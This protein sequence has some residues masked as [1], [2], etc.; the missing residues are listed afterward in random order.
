MV[1]RKESRAD[2]FQRQISNLRQQLGNDQ[3]DDELYDDAEP[4]EQVDSPEFNAPALTRR[5]S[6]SSFRPGTQTVSD[7]EISVIAPDS[8]WSGT[9]RA[10]GSLQVYGQVEGDLVAGDEIYIA[11]GAQVNARVSAS[12][13][14]VAGMVDG[15][16]ECS[17]RLEVLSTGRVS[18]DVTSPSLVVHDG[19][20]IE[21]DLRMQAP[22]AAE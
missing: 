8:M 2:S 21:G 13:V 20:T 10:N 14:T 16:I 11:A 17:S 4:M 15:T 19:A 12:V 5:P 7:A 3:E 9:L 1:F 18:G 22:E 6:P